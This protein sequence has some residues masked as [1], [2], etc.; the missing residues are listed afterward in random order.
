[1]SKYKKIVPAILLVFSLSGCSLF[2]D[3]SLSMDKQEVKDVVIE[4]NHVTGAVGDVVSFDADIKGTEILDW[5]AMTAYLRKFDD[6]DAGTISKILLNEDVQLNGTY[7]NNEIEDNSVVYVYDS[8]VDQGSSVTISSG[9]IYLQTLK[10]Q[11]KQ[12]SSFLMSSGENLSVEESKERF[13][14]ESIDGLDKSSVLDTF[15]ELCHSLELDISDNIEIYAMDMESANQYRDKN[16][17]LALDRNENKTPDWVEA[18]EAYFICA[19][20]QLNGME[21]PTQNT[22]SQTGYTYSSKVYAVIGRDGLYTFSAQGIYEIEEEEKKVTQIHTLQEVLDFIA[23]Y[24]SHLSGMNQTIKVTEI[25]LRYVVRYYSVS[26]TYQIVPVYVCSIESITTMSK[27]DAEEISTRNS[28]LYIDAQTL[29][30]YTG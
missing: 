21:L 3:G 18:D 5:S 12:Y 26:N 16:P 6:T 19:P 10:A 29:T 1:M 8:K 30:S 28:Y 17:W 7:E 22:S 25:N 14:N 2:P 20:L 27:E 4:D 24:Y 11:Q 15:T 23:T 13:P 9:R